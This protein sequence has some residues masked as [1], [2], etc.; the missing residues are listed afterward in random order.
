MDELGPDIV[1]VE[2]TASLEGTAATTA[3]R[4]LEFDEVRDYA[5]VQVDDRPAG[6]LQRTLRE[7][8]LTIPTG[9]SL[10]LL[11]EETGRV[12]YDDEDRRAQGPD[13]RPAHRRRG[14]PG[15]GTCARSTSPRSVQR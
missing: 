13:R 4:V 8:A 2:Y 14:D 9:R 6:I 7:N 11:V 3:R 1:L 10:R 12:N 15:P 5:W